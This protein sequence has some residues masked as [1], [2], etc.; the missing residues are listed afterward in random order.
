MNFF[1]SR[2]ARKAQSLLEA[3]LSISLGVILIGGSVGLIAVSLK[4]F[5]TAKQHLQANSLMRQTTEIIQSLTRDN[6]HTIYDLTPGIHYKLAKQGN[7]YA[8]QKGEEK[9][10]DSQNLVS[11]WSFDEATST[12]AYDN[13]STNNGTLTNGPTWQSESNCVSGSCLSFDGSDDYV[14]CG[15]P[16]ITGTFTV[17]AWAQ[18]ATTSLRTIIGTRSPSDA[19]F[20]MK[21]QNGNSI[22][23]DIGNGTT[24]ITTAADAS[25][26][27][28]LN[29]WYHLAYVVTPTGYT[30]YVNGN[31]VGSGSYAQNTPVFSDANHAIAIGAYEVRGGEY[32]FGLIDEVRIYNR[33]LSAAE[34]SA[35][36][37][38]T[39]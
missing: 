24:W 11:Y 19:G 21:F 30:I 6:W 31:Q 28:Q 1:H 34:I 36:Y 22:H 8:F 13:Q 15:N 23:G 33:A 26:N 20:D 14:N 4:T 38:A 25:F 18:V 39:K 9:I 12:I 3:L 17:E 10:F 32:F 7:A 27:Y 5:N 35:I 37:N 29:T 2:S 16:V